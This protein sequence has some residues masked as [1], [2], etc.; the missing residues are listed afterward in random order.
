MPA[1]CASHGHHREQGRFGRGFTLIELLVVIAIIAIL[2]AILFPVFARAR[3]QARKTTCTSNMKNVTL[4]TLM[5][6][7]DYDST[8][9][10][11]AKPNIQDADQGGWL[12]YNQLLQPYT[13][14]TRVFA[15]PSD[16]GCLPCGV[17]N[18]SLFANKKFTTSYWL[19]LPFCGGPDNG[20]KGR[21]RKD[22]VK[23]S[24]LQDPVNTWLHCEIWLWHNNDYKGWQNATAKSRVLSFADGSVRLSTEAQ[25][26]RSWIRI[27]PTP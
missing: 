1:R 6:V 14:N 22:G 8:F 9:P 17:T 11:V 24:E 20:D 15:C 10:V 5:Y 25:V 4:A 2:A 13:R 12:S 27:N 16:N 19:N 7:Q 21:V 23:E 26:N 3:E 18:T